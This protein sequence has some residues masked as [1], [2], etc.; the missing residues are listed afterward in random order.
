MNINLYTDSLRIFKKLR[1]KTKKTGIFNRDG[2][3]APKHMLT[4]SQ[5]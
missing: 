1:R 3:G 4:R 2:G 5:K